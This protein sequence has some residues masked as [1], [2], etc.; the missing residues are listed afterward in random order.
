[1]G[2]EAGRE[3]LLRFGALPDRPGEVPVMVAD[4]A[5]L[6]REV[7]FDA[8]PMVERDLRALLASFQ[9]QAAIKG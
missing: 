1:L 4:V 3:A 8:P 7:G 5:R 9:A 6:R 2:R